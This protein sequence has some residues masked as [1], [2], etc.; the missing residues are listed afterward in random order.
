VRATYMVDLSGDWARNLKASINAG[1]AILDLRLP[2]E[3]GVRVDVESGPHT[4]VARG[5]NQDG[6]VYTN[7]AY[8][9]SEVTL[10]IEIDAGIGHIN[11]EVEEEAAMLD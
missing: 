9:E 7:A 2:R 8:G 5:L 4:I 6:G 10:R 11:L 3:V 1:A